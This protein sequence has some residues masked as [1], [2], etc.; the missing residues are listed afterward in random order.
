M[1]NSHGDISVLHKNG[2]YDYGIGRLRQVI[3]MFLISKETAPFYDVISPKTNMVMSQNQYG[4][5][6]QIKY[7]I[8][9]NFNSILI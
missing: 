1:M 5:K 2:M 4:D 6:S 3:I 7:W 8:Y 9:E